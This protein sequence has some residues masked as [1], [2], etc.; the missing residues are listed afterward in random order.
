VVRAGL[1]EMS[2]ALLDATLQAGA[3]RVL[4]RAAALSD[5]HQEVLAPTT[6]VLEAIRTV[7]THTA[8]S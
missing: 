8:S 4:A 5:P 1:N 2:W 6:R 7:R 3:E